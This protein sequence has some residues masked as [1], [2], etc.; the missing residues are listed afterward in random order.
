MD[1]G[2]QVIHQVINQFDVIHQAFHS[3]EISGGGV[4]VSWYQVSLITLI[5]TLATAAHAFTI[6]GKRICF[7]IMP[8][9]SRRCRPTWLACEISPVGYRGDDAA[10]AR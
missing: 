7:F 9:S 1:K 10:S 2:E 6:I 8:A 4:H 3:G 5:K